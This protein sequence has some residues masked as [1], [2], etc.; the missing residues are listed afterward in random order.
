MNNQSLPV[1]DD[2]RQEFGY[3]RTSCDCEFCVTNC[4]YMPGFM[5]PSDIERMHQHIAPELSTEEFAKKY[6]RAS[7][8]A[9]VGQLVE[10][11]MQVFQ[12]PSLVP[13]RNP[14]TNH[15][16]FLKEGR[17]SIH[18][19][20]PYGCAFFD[21]KDVNGTADTLCTR[22][23]NKVME[24][25]AARGPYI[26]LWKMLQDAG[27]TAPGPSECR[28]AIADAKRLKFEPESMEAMQA[29][30]PKATMTPVIV[31]PSKPVAEH[32]RVGLRREHV[33]DFDNGLRL[34]VS[35]E[36]WMFQ[37]GDY[38]KLIHISA[39]LEPNRYLYNKLA[40]KTASA[41]IEEFA[42]TAIHFFKTLS[43]YAG[44]P[45][46]ANRTGHA[47]HWIILLEEGKADG[48]EEKQAGDR[49][50]GNP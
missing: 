28:K 4:Q 8:G 23:L 35:L 43:G 34:I 3:N 25:N 26:T 48:K 19:V 46:L 21:C 40:G 31:D 1:V 20:S 33:F 7:P 2:S 44:Q 41:A 39:G 38:K 30:Y 12:I 6:L 9:K 10:G 36:H 11:G 5:I 13:A 27:L 16:I 45:V 50:D 37:T 14:E 42:R 49:S 17:C 24:D 29:R 15:C 18:K 47:I 22:G 32:E